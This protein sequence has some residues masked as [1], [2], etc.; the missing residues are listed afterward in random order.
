ML[1]KDTTKK[2]VLP[3]LFSKILLNFIYLLYFWLHWV[4]IALCE[5]S[6]VVAGGGYSSLCCM[7]FLLWWLPVVEHSSRTHGLQ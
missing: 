1:N 7:G 2:L 3:P 6:L 5:L 4:F